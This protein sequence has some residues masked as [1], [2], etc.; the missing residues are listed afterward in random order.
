MF[1]NS[2]P[3]ALLFGL[4][5]LSSTAVVVRLLSER[6][7]LAPPTDQTVFSV[8]MM[9]EPAVVPTLMLIDALTQRSQSA[10]GALLGLAAVKS[11]VAVGGI[12]D[13]Q[14]ALIGSSCCGEVDAARPPRARANKN[15]AAAA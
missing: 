1:D 10:I 6:R 4:V 2:E 11:V 9:Q 15:S 7:E 14:T 12:P 3:G 8:L 5:S 13:R